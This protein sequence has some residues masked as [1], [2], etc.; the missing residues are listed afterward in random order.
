M[1]TEFNSQQPNRPSSA[2]KN[3]VEE[4]E[5]IDNSR[6]PIT[7]LRLLIKEGYTILTD[8]TVLRNYLD[9]D[10]EVRIKLQHPKRK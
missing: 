5:P 4:M 1:S 6:D 8:F 10:V 7:V 9:G 3:T 2:M